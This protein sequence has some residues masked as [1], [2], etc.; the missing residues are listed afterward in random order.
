MMSSVMCNFHMDDLQGYH[1]YDM[2]LGRYI[3]YK[4]N[5]NLCSSYNTIRWNGGTYEGCNAPMK[6]V[7]EVN[8]NSSP[9]WIIFKIF[10]NKEIWQ[11]KHVKEST[12]HTFAYYIIIKKIPTC[13][14]LQH[15]VKCYTEKI[16]WYFITY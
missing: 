5:V 3:F 7:S 8:F 12:W 16:M 11:R 14:I 15:K 10:R 13:V 9:N 4:L 6:H 1:R 2:I